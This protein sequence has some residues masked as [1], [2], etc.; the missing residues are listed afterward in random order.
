MAWR[1]PKNHETIQAAKAS[2]HIR[3]RVYR[4]GHGN[5][6]VGNPEHHSLAD[7]ARACQ[8]DHETIVYL[9]RMAPGATHKFF[10]G[11]MAPC[12]VYRVN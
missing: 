1:R 8:D 4:L 10:D 2:R 6:P 3:F 7:L 11:A 12:Q 9:F 5:A